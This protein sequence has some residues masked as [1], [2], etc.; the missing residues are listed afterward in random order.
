ML[1]IRYPRYFG[2]ME[3]LGEAA[4]PICARNADDGSGSEA[5]DG[6]VGNGAGPAN[7][8]DPASWMVN[9]GDSWLRA[10]V[11]RCTHC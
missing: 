5:G 7:L 10:P 2:K 1:S 8:R 11:M 9:D 6:A 3:A 4:G